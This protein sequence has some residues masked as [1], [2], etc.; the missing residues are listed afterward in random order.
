MKK[1]KRRNAGGC[2][3]L[4]TDYESVDGLTNLNEPNLNFVLWRLLAAQKELIFCPVLQE[5]SI[6]F[7]HFTWFAVNFLLCDLVRLRLILCP[8][9]QNPA[10]YAENRNWYIFTPNSKATI[11]KC[12]VDWWLLTLKK[13]RRSRLKCLLCLCSVYRRESF[14]CIGCWVETKG[15][16]KLLFMKRDS[17]FL[18]SMRTIPFIVVCKGQACYRVDSVLSVLCNN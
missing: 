11:C 4:W 18:A 16:A 13:C 10:N 15:E 12:L 3:L 5:N 9:L 7:I 8:T 14:S 17:C 2:N 6:F 1:K